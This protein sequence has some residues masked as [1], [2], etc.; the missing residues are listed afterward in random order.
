MAHHTECPR[1]STYHPTG[2]SVVGASG[3][4]GTGCQGTNHLLFA[5]AHWQLE[6]SCVHFPFVFGVS[7]LRDKSVTGVRVRTTPTW[8]FPASLP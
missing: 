2:L 7:W 1:D 6:Q 3:S 8:C 4:V 5:S